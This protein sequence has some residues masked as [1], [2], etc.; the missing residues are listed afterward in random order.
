[1]GKK[2][3]GFLAVLV[4]MAAAVMIIIKTSNGT[5]DEDSKSKKT[6]LHSIEEV[7]DRLNSEF[8]S[9]KD[10]TAK[11]YISNSISDDDLKKVNMSINSMKGSIESFT[12]YSSNV[13]NLS[14][15]YREVDFEYKRSD[16]MFVYDNIVNKVA[17]PEDRQEAIRLRNVCEK[18]LNDHVKNYMSDYD[19]EIAIHDYI[20][21]N[22]EYGFSEN[23]DDSEYTAY[24]CLVNR[25]AVC[26]G[27]SAAAN[28]LLMCAGVEC[29]IV[30]GLATQMVDGKESSEN[31]AWNQVKIDGEWYHL[32]V[33][34]D[35]PVGD[36]A[37]LIHEYFNVS[38]SVI[39]RNHET[40]SS[41][42]SKCESMRSNYYMKNGA[43]LYDV[44]SL[45][46]YVRICMSTGNSHHFE[47]A[48][49][50]IT[51]TD[52]TLQFIYDY[53]GVESVRYSLEG[54]REY[55]ILSVYINE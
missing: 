36:R 30:T 41:N 13:D 6:V 37:V 21:N 23:K 9:G 28:L 33:T 2:T 42:A 45:E 38:D 51:V 31:H 43:Y 22:C 15:S 11:L 7:A 49:N 8:D 14:D 19:K 18:I 46:N 47:C 54:S 35:D 32:D 39:N 48:L 17:I 52:E 26:S 3:F 24:G 29:K 50:G 55:N 12:T 53:T 40:Y 10:G 4:I 44:A 34:W 20:V 25:K 5:D 16:T 27:Y 1:M